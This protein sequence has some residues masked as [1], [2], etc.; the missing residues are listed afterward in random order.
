MGTTPVIRLGTF[1]PA[2]GEIVQIQESGQPG[3]RLVN[4][5]SG[6]NLRHF[7]VGKGE[8]VIPATD[9]ANNVATVVWQVDADHSTLS[10]TIL[11]R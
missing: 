2:Q 3:V 9:A 8:A 10:A 5:I 11:M 4:N 1:V 6:D 7:Q